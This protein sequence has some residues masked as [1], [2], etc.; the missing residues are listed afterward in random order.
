MRKF[1][2]T[3]VVAATAALAL[4][5]FA[6]PA[7]AHRGKGWGKRAMGTV[8]SFD[9]TT[10]TVTTTEG[11]TVTATFTE[12]TRVKVEHR[13]HHDKSG[14]PSE[15]DATDLVAGALVLKMKTND[16]GTLDR[17][18]VRPATHDTDHHGEP[19]DTDEDDTS[20]ETETEDTD[21]ETETETDDTSSQE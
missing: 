7:S 10:L 5:S 6:G 14:H 12:E 8:A 18:K 11:E 4:S 20:D 3:V 17:I 1:R 9:G 21:T 2:T 19:M 13:G 15:G 16:D